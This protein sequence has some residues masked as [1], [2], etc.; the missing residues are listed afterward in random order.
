M[1]N[2]SCGPDVLAGWSRIVMLFGVCGE[3]FWL[4]SDML[5]RFVRLARFNDWYRK[6][7]KADV[8]YSSLR[9]CVVRP[10]AV[11]VKQLLV[12]VDP[13]PVKIEYIETVAN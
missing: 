8:R 1:S 4:I 7:W 2:Q 11:N 6:R 13:F 10:C 9:R 5:Q 3:S 12:C